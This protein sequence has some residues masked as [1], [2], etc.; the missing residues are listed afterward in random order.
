MKI[1]DKNGNLIKPKLGKGR[2]AVKQHHQLLFKWV[3]EASKKAVDGSG[4]LIRLQE[5]KDMAKELKGNPL[6]MNM[7]SGHANAK[8][9]H[10]FLKLVTSGMPVEVNGKVEVQK[11]E[12]FEFGDAVVYGNLMAM[13]HHI[14]AAPKNKQKDMKARFDVIASLPKRE[15]YYK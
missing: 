6:N 12:A 1:I 14:A 2:R 9:R 5:A 3:T 15:S 11:L 8:V 7:T 10:W 4:E 13:K